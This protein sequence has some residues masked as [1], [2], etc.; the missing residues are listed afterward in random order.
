M[1]S[2]EIEQCLPHA[3]KMSL[4]NKVCHA[5]RSHLAATAISH[6]SCDNPLRYN[7][8]LATVNG[9][10][11]AAQAMALHG[12]MLSEATDHAI[13]KGYIATVRNIEIDSPFFP[14]NDLPIL[15]EVEQLMSDNNGFTYQF[16]ISCEKKTLISG[17]I[18]IFLINT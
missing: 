10:E 17:K 8:R 15:V 18:T 7:N 2:Q 5:D 9:I 13:Q 14:D 6:L 3:G 11:Y 4:L 16:Q 12:F 1:N